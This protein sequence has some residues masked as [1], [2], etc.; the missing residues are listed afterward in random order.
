MFCSVCGSKIEETTRFCPGCGRKIIPEETEI[1]EKPVD[2]AG[3]IKE[4]LMKAIE[5]I[6]K[7]ENALQKRTIFDEYRDSAKKKKDEMISEASSASTTVGCLGIILGIVI[8]IVCIFYSLHFFLTLSI[9]AGYIILVWYIESNVAES[10]NENEKKAQAIEW[11]NNE[12]ALINEQEAR[13]DKEFNSY[14]VSD[15]VVL[16]RTIVPENYFDKEPIQFFIK[17]LDEHRA[18]TFKEAINLYEEYLYR[19]NMA[20]MQQQ[21]LIMQGQQLKETHE[22]SKN[23]TNQMQRQSYYMQQISD[24]TK[25]T[26]RAIKINAAINAA[27][28]HS[29]AK[30]LKKIRKNMR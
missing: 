14:C 23:V 1:I 30:Q 6:D 28:G 24:N 4:I 2:N 19:E 11:Y 8:I 12:I 16:V 21:Q 9:M 17:M 26:Q 3:E 18:D 25:S 27:A 20:N 15:E 29:Q 22:L 10:Y 13:F 7:I 5:V